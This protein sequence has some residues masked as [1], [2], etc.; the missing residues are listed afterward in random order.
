MHDYRMGNKDPTTCI[1]CQVTIALK[2]I[3]MECKSYEEAK[4]KHKINPNLST[5]PQDQTYRVTLYHFSQRDGAGQAHLTILF[6]QC[7]Y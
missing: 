1:S 3:F 5:N 4:V 7:T 6:F 2:H